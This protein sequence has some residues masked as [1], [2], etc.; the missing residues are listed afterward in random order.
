LRLAVAKLSC[1]W[2]LDTLSFLQLAY[3]RSMHAKPALLLLPA[4][5]GLA[6]SASA[7]FDAENFG[8]GLR[9]KYGPPLH[10]EVF[11]VPP[12]EMVVDYAANGHPCRIQLPAIGP[13]EGTNV[14][15][16]KGVDDFLLKLLPLTVR[17]K[18]LGK[19]V[20]MFGLPGVLITHYENVTISESLEGQRR[21]GV[22]VIFPKEQCQ[23]GPAQ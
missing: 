23:N 21:T 18:E 10:R 14:S 8:V 3:Y 17:G 11:L 22:T 12:G 9:A 13:E 20:E 19:M 16:A 2:L 4:F 15:S 5:I 7:Q 1:L 6:V